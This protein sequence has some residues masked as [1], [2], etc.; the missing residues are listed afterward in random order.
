MSR[1]IKKLMP[2]LIVAAILGYL[3]WPYV[4]SQT[5]RPN[6]VDSEAAL[7]S[8]VRSLVPGD[9]QAPQRDPFDSKG[10]VRRRRRGTGGT[11]VTDPANP[12]RSQQ[13]S[14]ATAS[15]G[16]EPD[17]SPNAGP[18]T[19][20]P[21]IPAPSYLELQG[22]LLCGD[23]RVALINGAVYSEGEELKPSGPASPAY[24]VS[25]IYS[26]RVLLE[27]ETESLEL[28]YRTIE[29]I[30]AT[31]PRGPSRDMRVRA[32]TLHKNPRGSS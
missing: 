4:D 28:K 20:A 14:V 30:P 9:L 25:R 10:L 26:H 3:C 22:T 29:K 5:P 18:R 6:D 24:L 32:N 11:A 8:L 7:T 27:S 13:E 2:L 12:D 15:A 16:A 21:P 23:R 19:K 17:A 1:R 31:G